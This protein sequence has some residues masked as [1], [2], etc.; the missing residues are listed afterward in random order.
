M[1]ALM[2]ANLEKMKAS[3]ENT[4]STVRT[5]RNEW[6]SSEE[7]MKA[8]VRASQESMEVSQDKLNAEWRPMKKR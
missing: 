7:E 8:T 5:A 1:E 4:E 3:L 2:D 6:E